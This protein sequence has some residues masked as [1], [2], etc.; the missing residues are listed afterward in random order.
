MKKSFVFVGIL[1]G[2]VLIFIGIF[3]PD[4]KQKLSDDI[5]ALVD[6][7]PILKSDLDL[8]LKALSMN[9]DNQ[10]TSEQI[11]L[12]KDRLIDEQLL[13]QRGIDLD[14][15]QTSNPIRKL[16]VNSMID[17]VLSE[18]NDFLIDD[19]NLKK[20]YNDNISFFLPSKELRLKLIFLKFRS[21]EEDEKR[22]DTIRER[23]INGD[24]FDIVSKEEGDTYLPKI[25]DT[26]L[27]ERKLKDYIDPNLVKNA[28]NLEDGQITSEIETDKG[29]CFLY[30]VESEK[31]EPLPFESMRDKIKS[32]YKRRKDEEALLNYIEWLRKKYDIIYNESIDE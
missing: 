22:L 2:L 10:I 19:K 28:F 20:F 25:P 27:P 14:L 9:K 32:E 3:N 31:G 5:V 21:Q 16:I 17:N 24:D 18:N 12:V 23:L 26:F 11:Q 7:H 6:N 1:L 30:L 8:A 4:K 29:Y 13:L 15:H